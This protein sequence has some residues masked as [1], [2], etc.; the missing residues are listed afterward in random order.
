MANTL[1]NLIPT[2][3][4]ALD[5]VSRKRKGFIPA[6]MRD[7]AASEAALNQSVRVPIVPATTAEADNTPAVTAPDTGDQS[8]DSV[9]LTISKSKHIPIR[10]TGEETKGLL[11]AG[12]YNNINRDRVVQAIERLDNL[13]E[14]DLASS[15]KYASRAVGTPAVTPF[16]TA[17]DLTDFAAAMRIMDDNGA[18]TSDLKMILSNAS[19]QNIRGKQTSL[20]KA[21]EAG[22]DELLRDG[23]IMR[24]MGFDIGQSGF[25][26][27]HTA[28]TGASATTNNAGYAA[29]SKTLTLASAGTG[30]I[31][32]GDFLNFASENDGI[33]YGVRSGDADVSNGGTV[34]LNNPGLRFAM[35]AA[36]KAITTKAAFSANL[37]FHKNA[38]ILA[39]RVPAKPA[40][41]DAAQDIV[42]VVDPLTGL[43]YEFAHYPQFHQSPLHVRIAWGWQPIKQDHIG[44][45]FG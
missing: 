28:G 43:V 45:V 9:E 37:V 36:T 6:V 14:T 42:T 34:T 16:A 3:Y 24:V 18:P 44:V 31:L 8:I 4:E 25:V 10:W 29:G 17:N 5:I 20:F 38:I 23:K 13:I 27:S 19:M 30:T 41:G 11:N 22:T 7:S 15:Y 40:L 12:T 21:N 35:S 32:E 39:T 1:T 33:S 26:A 2:F